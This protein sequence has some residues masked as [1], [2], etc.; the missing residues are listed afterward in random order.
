[1]SLSKNYSTVKEDLKKTK[2]QLQ[3]LEES[4]NLKSVVSDLKNQNRML[5]EA[6]THYK[7]EVKK[8]EVSKAE[9]EA[10]EQQ[11]HE[12]QELVNKCKSELQQIHYNKVQESIK[13]SKNYPDV[14][15]L[16]DYMLTEL[17][18][19]LECPVLLVEMMNP[20][21]T[22]SGSTIDGNVLDSYLA[23]KKSD[24][25]FSITPNTPKIPNLLAASVQELVH[26]VEDKK[27]VILKNFVVS[28]GVGE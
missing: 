26:K 11:I 24:Q 8:I 17:H 16:L 9:V 10:K 2:N 15:E 12:L 28:Q 3:N 19:L 22:P 25:A 7:K 18:S 4:K 27:N 5:R 14:S 13:D 23:T 20:C 21:I 1:M 6:N